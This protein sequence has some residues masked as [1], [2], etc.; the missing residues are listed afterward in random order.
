MQQ[1]KNIEVRK[2][3]SLGAVCTLSYLAV[4]ASRNILSAIT[5]Q[6]LEDSFSVEFI[7]MMSTAWMLSYA[8]GQLINGL[9]GD[10]VPAKYMAGGGLTLAGICNFVL[11]LS[12]PGAMMLIFYTLSG[13]FL[14]MVYAPIV[15]LVAE[16]TLPRYASRC[17]LGFTVASLF[18]TPLAGLLAVIFRWRTTFIVCAAILIV[19]GVF[20]FFFLSLLERCGYIKRLTTGGNEKTHG[21]VNIRKLLERDI[22]RFSIVAMLTGIV[23]TSVQF[24]VPTYLS[25]RLGYTPEGAATAFMVITLILS[26]APWLT[27]LVIYDILLKRNMHLMLRLSFGL[28]TVLFALMLVLGQ[29][30]TNVICLTLAMLTCGA[31]ATMLYSV[32]CPSLKDTGSVSTATG[33]IDFI[34]YGSA[35]LANL[36]FANAI[37]TIGWTW[38]I[39]IWALLMLSGFIL[40]LTARR[41]ATE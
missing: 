24:W 25:Q 16:N 29:G 40:A 28:S 1:M 20:C 15:K 6:M 37:E 4:Y 17:C 32:Y 34:S 36:L 38:L 41:S 23:R 18:G 39:I 13:F 14:S 35:A 27:N 2:A 26:M 11:Q 10:H 9:I 33:F 12:P 3:L 31:S 30:L 21:S 5:P 7:G 22:I 19:M 8:I